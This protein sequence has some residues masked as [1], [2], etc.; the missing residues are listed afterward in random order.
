LIGKSEFTNFQKRT[1]WQV[2]KGVKAGEYLM[3]FFKKKLEK[4]VFK[5]ISLI[6]IS[7]FCAFM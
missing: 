7:G 2:K 1:L 4:S 5:N 6:T 3:L